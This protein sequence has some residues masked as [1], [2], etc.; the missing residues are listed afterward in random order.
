MDDPFA[1][2]IVEHKWLA[3]G[4]ILVSSDIAKLLRERYSEEGRDHAF[5]HALGITSGESH[6]TSQPADPGPAR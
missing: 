4:T 5:L 1:I 6:G 3:A 2:K